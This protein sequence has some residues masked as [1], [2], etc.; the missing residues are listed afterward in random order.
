[1][2]RSMAFWASL[3]F[4]A[5]QALRVRRQALRLEPASG[6]IAGV[7]GRGPALR[8]LAIGD[9]IIAGV[10]ASTLDKALVGRT[11]ECLATSLGR[12]VSWQALGRSGI[13]S[14]GVLDE[15][16]PLLPEARVDVFLVSIG[17]NDVTSL[18]RTS[19]WRKNLDGLFH[20]LARHSSESLIAMAGIP[21]L[22]E[23]P[24]LPQPLRGVIGFRGESFDRETREVIRA[25]PQALHVPVMLKR[26]AGSFCPDGFHPSETSYSAFGQ[27]VADQ[28]VTRLSGR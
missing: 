9:S 24:L 19:T 23:F 1:M 8:L 6:P 28:L 18:T 20:A 10:G 16:L 25:H 14:A 22:G 7:V 17:V 13:R 4:I 12:T 2:L 15:L 11:A 21:P 26:N 5:P 3:P 27:A